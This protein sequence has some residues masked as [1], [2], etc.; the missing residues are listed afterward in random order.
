MNENELS[1][2]AAN[3]I[4]WR[5]LMWR[6]L[7]R[8]EENQATTDNRVVKLEVKNAVFGS[9]FGFVFGIIGSYIFK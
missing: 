2:V 4:E 8:V 3:E 9:I 7:E 6:K 5:K 1:V